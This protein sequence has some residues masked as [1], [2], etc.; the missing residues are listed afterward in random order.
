MGEEIAIDDGAYFVIDEMTKMDTSIL[1]GIYLKEK[2]LT[3][4]L[5]LT[6]IAN[7]NSLF[8]IYIIVLY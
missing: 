8:T 7:L 5:K 4:E 3:I 6:I 2:L 1:T